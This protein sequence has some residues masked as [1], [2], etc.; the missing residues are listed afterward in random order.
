MVWSEKARENLQAAERL[1]P[2]EALE[3]DPCLN[4]SASR[5]YYAAY[6]AVATIAATQG[7][8]FTGKAGKEYYLHDRFPADARAWGILDDNGKEKLE[9]LYACRI[10][11][12]YHK[13]NVDFEEANN[14]FNLAKEL[15]FGLLG[16]GA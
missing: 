9:V 4:A 5:S 7:H 14:A 13:A 2:G 12:D 10:V 3:V 15:V 16:G 8:E 1:L 6:L 11:A